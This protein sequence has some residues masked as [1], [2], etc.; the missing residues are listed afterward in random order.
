MTLGTGESS[1]AAVE[2]TVDVA[3]TTTT[4][5]ILDDE[6]DEATKFFTVIDLKVVVFFYLVNDGT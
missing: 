5:N 1:N 4:V 6:G 2:V 3:A